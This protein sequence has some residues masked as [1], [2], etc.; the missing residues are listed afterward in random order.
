MARSSAR[1]TRPR[2]APRNAAVYR[3]LADETR[4]EILA[5]L[6]EAPLPAGA[7][8][9][10]F[11]QISRPAVSKHLAVLREA[12]LVTDRVVGRERVYALETRPLAEVTA[13][14]AQLDA[15]WR[16]ALVDLGRHLDE[17]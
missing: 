13:Y 4:R 5:M 1:S 17:T 10:A 3:A 8:A 2:V 11:P 12:G 16:R 7:V 9:A 15:M 6:A 14:I